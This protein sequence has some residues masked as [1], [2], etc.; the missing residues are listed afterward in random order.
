VVPVVPA[1][2][3]V[4][5]VPAVPVVPV[6]ATPAPSDLAQLGRGQL[7]KCLDFLLHFHVRQLLLPEYWISAASVT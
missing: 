7:S 1:V 5:V 6:M 4:P 2:P 3:V